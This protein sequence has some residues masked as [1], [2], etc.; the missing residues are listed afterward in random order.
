M[1]MRMRAIGTAS[2]LCMAVAGL[3]ACGSKAAPQSSAS[4][5]AA[6]PANNCTTTQP[7]QH[8]N[9]KQYS[10]APPMTID[11]TKTYTATFDTSCGTFTAMLD[12]KTAPKGVNNFVFLAR[13]GFYNG[14]TFH[15][16]V[17][18]FVIQGGDPKGDGTGGPGYDV[19]T[20]TPTDGYHDGDLAWAKTQ[21]DPPGAAGSQFFVVTG[22]VSGLDT[23]TQGSAY[24]YGVF[25]HVTSGLAVAKT[26]EGFAPPSGDGAPTQP[27]YID[28]VTITEH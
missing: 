26:I 10:S 12:A 6:R 16:V 3:A 9:G 27:V 21:T 1:K 28:T 22:D 18:D 25:G 11:P 13:A 17:T 8:G 20:E 15:R 14:L 7:M 19:V 23:K 4:S 24:D 2:V 5:S